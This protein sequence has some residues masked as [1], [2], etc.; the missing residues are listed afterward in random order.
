MTQITKTESNYC[1]RNLTGRSYKLG[2]NS[3]CGLAN[4]KPRLQG[5]TPIATCKDAILDITRY[6]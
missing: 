6:R 1:R 4:W 5:F 3:S 2:K